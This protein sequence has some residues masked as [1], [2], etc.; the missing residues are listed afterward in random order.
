MGKRL[1][2]EVKSMESKRC[3]KCKS[4]L[5]EYYDRWECT[6]YNYPGCNYRKYKSEYEIKN[7]K[8]QVVYK[9][10]QETKK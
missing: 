5:N 8:F 6:G 9:T 2:K 1:K 3:P 10:K 7:K 4:Y